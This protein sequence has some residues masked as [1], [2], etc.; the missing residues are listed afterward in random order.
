[1]KGQTMGIFKRISDILSANIN[2]LVEGFENPE[3]MLKQAIREMEDS[4]NEATGETAKAL[5]GEKRLRRELENNERQSDQWG[6]RAET[7]VNNQDDELARKA[8]MRKQ[9]HDKLAVAL[10][11]QLG[12]AEQASQ[13]L[14][15]QLDGMKAK[16]AEAKRTLATL[17]ARKRAADFQKKMQL[18]S[19][20]VDATDADAF[21]KFDRMREKVEQAEAEAAALAELSSDLGLG[22]DMESSSRERDLE[23]EA[24]LEA[25]KK[26]NKKKN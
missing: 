16:L 26:Q 7:A 24:Q 13:T 12:S 5:A 20:K 8:L 22:P 6:E 19:A 14:R 1:M 23:I 21:A 17:S 10:R 2:D 3:K 18:T 4:I 15:H 9:E 25:L 11:D